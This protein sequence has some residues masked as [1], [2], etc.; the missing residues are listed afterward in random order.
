M[1][2][3]KFNKEKNETKRSNGMQGAMKNKEIRKICGKSKLLL[4]IKIMVFNTKL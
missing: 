1:F 3:E 4:L 2:Q